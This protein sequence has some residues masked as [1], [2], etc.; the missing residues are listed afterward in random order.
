[1]EYSNWSLPQPLKIPG[2]L[3]INQLNYQKLTNGK[4]PSNMKNSQDTPYPKKHFKE[5]KNIIHNASK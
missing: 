5:C 2:N 1:M 3:E 4:N